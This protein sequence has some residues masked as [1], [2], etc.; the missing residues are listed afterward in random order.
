[1]SRPI[2]GF[3][4]QNTNCA[5][6]EKTSVEYTLGCTLTQS[7]TIKRQSVGQSLIIFLKR[8]VDKIPPLFFVLSLFLLFSHFSPVQL[9]EELMPF[10]LF[11]AK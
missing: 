3:V 9:F 6:R 1:M 4:Y 7:K 8:V 11:C 10:S 5:L 2:V